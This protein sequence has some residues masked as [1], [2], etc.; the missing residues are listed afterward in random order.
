MAA[1]TDLRKSWRVVRV[2]VHKELLQTRSFAVTSHVQWRMSQSE[3]VRQVRAA[4][5]AV[6]S[7]FTSWTRSAWDIPSRIFETSSP[8][9]TLSG[10]N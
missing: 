1:G 8:G 6:K 5:R 7:K 10:C 3:A 2:A 4:C 9:A